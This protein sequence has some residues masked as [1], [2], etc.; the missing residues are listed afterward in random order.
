MLIRGI[1]WLVIDTLVRR[2]VSRATLT[3]KR[4]I[5][6]MQDGFDGIN[7]S[8]DNVQQAANVVV[9][10]GGEGFLIFGAMEEA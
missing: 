6:L 7:Q 4:D 3:R 5:N 10:T 8:Q 2:P 1:Y 9:A